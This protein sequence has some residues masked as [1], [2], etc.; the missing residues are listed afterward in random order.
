MRKVVSVDIGYGDVKVV[1]SEGGGL[2]QEK[3]PTAIASIS[4]ENYSDGTL[5]KKEISFSFEGQ[6]YSVGDIAKANAIV[7]TSYEFLYKYSPLVLYYIIEKFNIDY[8]NTVIG[9]GLP[10]SY[11]TREKIDNMHHRLK[12]FAV[13]DISISAD[14]KIFAQGVGCFF[15]YLFTDNVA[16]TNGIVVD[17]GYNTIEFIVIQNGKVKKADSRGMIK[18]GLSMLVVE[19]QKIIQSK[20]ELELTEQ[21]TISALTQECITLYGKEISLTEEISK[22]KRWY[23]DTIIQNLIGMYDDK[24]KKS[25]IIILAGGGAYHIKDFLPEKYYNLI[26]IPTNSEFSN[27]RGFF[28]IM[29]NQINSKGQ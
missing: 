12:K 10:L 26:Y 23:A 13:N 1:F 2:R 9:L 11:Y 3:F 29:Q 27:A 28:Y 14:V 4:S 22:L 17:V 5:F 7:T 15:D 19:L 21:E 25:D 18:K 8:S 20:Y 6:L 24:I 16:I